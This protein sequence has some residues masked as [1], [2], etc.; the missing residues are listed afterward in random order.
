M[1]D[2]RQ[3][4]P[5]TVSIVL[6]C[7]DAA[8]C[9]ETCLRSVAE[10]TYEDVEFIVIDGASEDGTLDMLAKYRSRLAHLVSEPDNGIYPAMNKGLSLASG[11]LV[12]FLGADDYL[13]DERVIADVV[14]VVQSHPEGDVYYGPIEVRDEDGNKGVHKPEGPEKSAEVMVCGCLPHQS[15]FARRR[16][17]DRTGPFD[18]RY[19]YHADYDWFLKIIADPEIELIRFDRVVASFRMGGMSS[20]LAKGQ[21]EAY[22]IQNASALYKSQEWSER[23]IAIFQ[24]ALLATRI[25][26]A[27]FRAELRKVQDVQIENA[28]LKEKLRKLKQARK[29]KSIG[30]RAG[31]ASFGRAKALAKNVLRKMGITRALNVRH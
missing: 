18:E 20:Q 14:D 1:R 19:R 8:N 3:T 9:I 12:Y 28:S 22:R 27:Q 4:Q 11:D 23:R 6:V 10:Q 21:P 24:E 29:H 30:E 7:R 15:T 17:F 16:V 31:G 13:V 26:E 25:R 5:I 2:M